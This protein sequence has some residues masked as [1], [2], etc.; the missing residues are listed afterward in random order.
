MLRKIWS[1]V[2]NFIKNFFT[3]NIG[4]KIIVLAVAVL[5]WAYVLSNENPYRVKNVTNVNLSFEGEAELL[6]KGLCIRGDRSE[7]LEQVTV[8]VKTQIANYSALGTGQLNASVSLRNI[9]EARTYELPVTATISSGYGVIQS[10]SPST[11]EVEVDSLVK[12][13]IPIAPVYIGSLPDGYWPDMEASS[14]TSLIDIE[15]PRTDISKVKRAECVIDLTNCTSLLY[16]T[17]DIIM[18]DAEDEVVDPSIIIGTIPSATVRVPI[19]PEKYVKIDTDTALTGTDSLSVSNYELVSVT[20]SP[21]SIRIVGEAAALNL[22]D[23]LSVVPVDVSS[24]TGFKTYTTTLILPEGIRIP[25][26]NP[27]VSISVDVEE[28]TAEASFDTI[29][30]ALNGLSEDLAASS[31]LQTVTVSVEGP[32]SAVNALSRSGITVLVDL[33]NLAEGEYDVPFDV[34]FANAEVAST[35]KFFVSDNE[36]NVINNV[37]VAITAKDND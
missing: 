2:W 36:G 20:A 4:L 9:S 32:Y 5:L 31:V 1:F 23:E 28:R 34:V 3:K 27:G 7:I 21:E 16:S 29:A 10:I 25:D 19:Y 14:V 35:L 11:I 24:Q 6:A 33:S 18:Y 15:G 12:K 22:V 17:Y 37:H 26:N 30:L 13:T 8:S